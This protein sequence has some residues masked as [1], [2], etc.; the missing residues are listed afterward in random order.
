VQVL[1]KRSTTDPATW[2][3]GQDQV[4]SEYRG[5]STVERYIDPSDTS[6]KDFAKDSKL[7]MDDYY[8]FRIISTK[9]FA[10]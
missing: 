4:A 2:V 9:R 10:P 5:S 1:R 6:L 8:K 3:E 7:S